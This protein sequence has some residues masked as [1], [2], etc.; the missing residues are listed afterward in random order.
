[1]IAVR[2]ADNQ[3]SASIS[4]LAHR[5]WPNTSEDDLLVEFNE[6][7]TNSQKAFFVASEHDI[8]IGF[9]YSTLRVDYVEGTH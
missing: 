1:M 5:L 3:D 2:Q 4:N 9:A 7:V 6:S 8:I